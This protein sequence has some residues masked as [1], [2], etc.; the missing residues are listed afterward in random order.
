VKVTP[1]LPPV[2]A[3]TPFA[4]PIVLYAGADVDGCM[5]A[6]AAANAIPIAAPYVVPIPVPIPDKFPGIESKTFS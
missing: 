2:L 6:P 3:P 1:P 4:F 5:S